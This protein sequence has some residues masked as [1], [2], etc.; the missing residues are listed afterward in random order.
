MWSWTDV[1]L[2]HIYCNSN[3]VFAFYL[4]ICM[5]PMLVFVPPLSW[6]RCWVCQW[7][8]VERVDAKLLS[9]CSM[10][11]KTCVGAHKMKAWPYWH[12]KVRNLLSLCVWS[13]FK[14]CLN[15]PRRSI[16]CKERTNGRNKGSSS[17]LHFNHRWFTRN[18]NLAEPPEMCRLF[19]KKIAALLDVSTSGVIHSIDITQCTEKLLRL[20]CR[21]N[22]SSPGYPK[23]D[24]SYRFWIATVASV[25]WAAVWDNYFSNEKRNCTHAA[26]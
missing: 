11:W 15:M 17:S 25:T 20:K 19:E 21:I 5:F 24:V 10:K 23:V 1:D 12:M 9:S 4:T 14:G 22:P 6:G 2:V 7:S 3:N 13:H 8:H 16:P 18:L 26:L